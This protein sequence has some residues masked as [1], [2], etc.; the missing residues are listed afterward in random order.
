MKNKSNNFLQT[1]KAILTFENVK[2]ILDEKKETLNKSYEDSYPSL[3]NYFQKDKITINDFVVGSHFVYGWMPTILELKITKEN[4]LLEILNK[5]KQIIDFDVKEIIIDDLTILKETINNSIVGASKLL[6]FINPSV[7][8]IWDSNIGLCFFEK[9]HEGNVNNISNYVDYLK[10]IHEFLNDESWILAK[11][12]LV[13][14][15]K[16]KSQNQLSDIR[17]IE[18]ILFLHGKSIRDKLKEQKLLN[19]E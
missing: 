4:E 14:I 6:H 17:R 5:Y 12:A 7:F 15:G 10:S 3:V 2:K 11:D 19:I 18:Y 13:L 16:E 8:P 9:T 1:I